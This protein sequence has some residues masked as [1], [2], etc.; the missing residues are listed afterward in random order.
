MGATISAAF[1]RVVRVAVI[2][3]T[4]LEALLVP[5][6]FPLFFCDWDRLSQEIIDLL[7]H[8]QRVPLI[9]HRRP[10]LLL[11]DHVQSLKDRDHNVRVQCPVVLLG[12]PQRAQ[13]PVRHLLALAHIHVEDIFCDL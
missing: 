8:I 13:L 1:A 4:L 11:V 7:L 9:Q 5:P 3:V 6:F 10:S 2:L 12:Q